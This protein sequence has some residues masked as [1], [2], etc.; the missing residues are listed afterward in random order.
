MITYGKF[1]LT[2]SIIESTKEQLMFLNPMGVGGGG[3]QAIE[4]CAT[5]KGRNFQPF[6]S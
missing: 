4:V 6:W 3:V 2:Q 1:M 5:P